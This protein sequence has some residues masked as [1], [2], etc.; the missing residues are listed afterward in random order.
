MTEFVLEIALSFFCL[1]KNSQFLK[2][3]LN[4]MKQTHFTQ[5]II[6]VIQ[7]LI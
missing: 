1:I 3:H 7:I 2:I 4:Y 5:I 6:L